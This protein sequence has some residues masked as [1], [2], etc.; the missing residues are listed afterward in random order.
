MQLTTM[1]N[2][3][4]A[5]RVDANQI[6]GTG[7]FMRCLALA[8]ELSLQGAEIGF[9]SRGLPKHCELMLKQ[10]N[11]SLHA[12]PTSTDIELSGDLMHTHWLGTS[13]AKDAVQTI[14]ALES[15]NWDWLV[16]DHYALDQRFETKLRSAVKNI[17]VI[18]DLADRVHDCDLL[19]DQ[20]FQT[21]QAFRYQDKVPKHCQM[22]LGPSFA[23][24]RQEFQEARERLRIRS[25]D[26]KNILVFF[27]GVDAEN[28]TGKVLKV[29]IDLRLNVQVNVVIGEQHPQRD[30]IQKMCVQHHFHCHV[31]TSQ[32][33]S[34]LSK[35]DLVIGAGGTH[36]WER[37][38]LGV[39]SF[40]IAT[41]ANQM[42]QLEELQNAG[43]LISEINSQNSIKTL[44]NFLDNVSLK[45]DLLKGWSKK[46]VALVDGKGASKTV[47]AIK[48]HMLQIRMANAHDAQNIY[49]WRN[50]PQIRKNSLS[51]EEISWTSH[52]RWFEERLN[53]KHGPILI[54]EV[55]GTPVGVVRFDI[56]QSDAEVSIYLVPE[57]GFKGWGGVLLMKS[58][59]WLRLKY[60]KVL[61]LHANVLPDNS[62]SIKLFSKQNYVVDAHTSPMEF[63]KNMETSP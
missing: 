2:L 56:H 24:L 30:E 48:A 28:H 59:S 34:L 33:A 1:S 49:K 7:H 38:C 5:F 19:L 53:D 61:R 17:M 41:A 31:Q 20:N 18:D 52:Q 13:Q 51:T 40:C 50:H 58:E 23:L 39:P 12:L 14:H 57:S 42:Q 11:I 8:D 43:L 55:K 37:F 15:I 21:N 26:L 9:V 36:V 10:K 29:L 32:M 27:G 25:G 22:L 54:G 60:P 3:R 63:M 35:A 45:A 16:I 4:I 44:T 46:I 62:S 6:I 47:A